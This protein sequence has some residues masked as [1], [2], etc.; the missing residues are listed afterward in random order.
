MCQTSRFHTCSLLVILVLSGAS[1]S[2]GRPLLVGY[3]GQNSAGPANGPANNE[4]PLK[5]VCETTKYDVLAVAF[6]DSF[7]DVNNKDQ[8]PSLNLNDHCSTPVSS[9]YPKLLRCPSIQ[10]GIKE[11]QR[12]GKKVLISIGGPTGDGTLPTPAK[13]KE[14][15]HTLFN[16]FLGGSDYSANIRPFGE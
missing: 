6:V 2:P 4:R 15:A 5:D 11:C 9:Q 14:L 3:W 13:A 12:R 7:W 10:E 16:L 8:L 1:S